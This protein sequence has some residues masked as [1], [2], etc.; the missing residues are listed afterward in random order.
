MEIQGLKKHFPVRSGFLSPKLTVKAVDDVSF[1]IVK[2]ETFGLVGES[3]CGKT[4]LGRCMLRLIE[5]TSG[6]V[7]FRGQ[8]VLSIDKKELRSMRRHMQIVFQ[9]PYSS[10]DPRLTVRQTIRIPLRLHGNVQSDEDD[11]V[12]NL[13]RS[14][15]LKDEHIDRYPHEFSGGQRQRIVIA[16]A[17]AGN[18]EF[19]I[20]DEPTSALDVSVQATIL[21]LLRRLQAK[22]SLTYLFISHN[23]ETVRYMSN[24]IGVMYLGKLVEIASAE[25]LFQ[26]QLHPYTQALFSAVPVPDPELR[27]KKILL[28]GDVPTPINPPGGCRFH[29]RCPKVMPKCSEA[30]PELVEIEKNHFVACHLY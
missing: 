14:V 3:G 11:A 10:L 12:L 6:S 5:P 9:D 21:N 19:L 15:G 30:Q 16:R 13:I 22:L 8:D 23:L 1:G 24:R 26:K 25:E 18:P 7:S 27:M 2:G 29:P 17:L 28:T 4:T 20:L